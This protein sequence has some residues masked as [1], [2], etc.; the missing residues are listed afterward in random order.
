MNLH[1]LHFQ[2]KDPDAEG[3][4]VYETWAAADGGNN[5]MLLLLLPSICWYLLVCVDFLNTINDKDT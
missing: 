4:S 1:L 3:V 5:V 2:V